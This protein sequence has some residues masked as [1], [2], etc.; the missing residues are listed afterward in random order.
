LVCYLYKAKYLF[1]KDY[2]N[3]FGTI[4]ESQVEIA[5]EKIL[6]KYA[7][8]VGCKLANM[9]GVEI[10]ES[11]DIAD[12]YV[13]QHA[14]G[15]GGLNNSCMR[16]GTVGKHV[17]DDF[18]SKLRDAGANVSVLFT[19]NSDGLLTSRALLWRI[20]DYVYL[21]RVYGN[22]DYVALYREYAI[23]NDFYSYDWKNTRALYVYL[24]KNP[25]FEYAPYMDTFRYLRDDN[26][27]TGDSN[28]YLEEYTSTSGRIKYV[29]DKC[30]Y[31]GM[32][33]DN[34]ECY[35]CEYCGDRVDSDDYCRDCYRC[36][37]C[38]EC[39]RCSDCSDVVEFV[40]PNCSC[41]EHCCECIYCDYCDS[42]VD[43]DSYCHDCERC[44]NCCDC[45]KCSDCECVISD[46]DT[47]GLCDE[48]RCQ[49]CCDI[50]CECE[51]GETKRRF[52]DIA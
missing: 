49:A 27:L 40:C 7:D 25:C 24:T 41:C 1:I 48:G 15:C 43:S 51:I 33:V 26:V 38:C 3:Y 16:A 10:L 42:Y 36:C 30:E 13:T 14:D 17:F 23:E 44:H 4:S 2:Y 5:T 34:C 37:D 47:F 8:E 35:Q 39:L 21:D 50:N 12:I 19:K 22:A 45:I 18:Y 11:V 20:D 6:K 52:L 9:V 31:C 32:S 28:D 46:N 29:E